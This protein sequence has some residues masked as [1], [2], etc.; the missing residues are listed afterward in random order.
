MF[1]A[2]MTAMSNTLAPLPASLYLPTFAML[3]LLTSTYATEI[4]PLLAAGAAGFAAGFGAACATP[5][6]AEN[7]RVRAAAV[8]A[9]NRDRDL[10]F[11]DQAPYWMRVTGSACGDKAFQ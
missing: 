5:A 10:V 11:I 7:A 3:L 1:A 6:A 4:G 2:K 8:T 9:V